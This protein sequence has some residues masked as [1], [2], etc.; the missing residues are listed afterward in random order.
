[1]EAKNKMSFYDAEERKEFT[2]FNK[3]VYLK[4]TPGKHVIRIL[5]AEARKYYS[6]WISGTSIE[7]LGDDCPQCQL[8]DSILVEVNNKYA[9][10]KNVTGFSYRQARGVVNVLDRTPVK[11]CVKCQDEMKAINNVWPAACR[12]CGTLTNE[13]EIT[14]SGKVKLLSKADIVFAQ[15]GSFDGSVLDED[16]NALGLMDFDLNLITVGNNTVADPT[17]TIDKVSVPDDALFDLEKASIRLDKDEM[18]QRI[19]GVSLKDIFSARNVET[20]VAVESSGSTAAI[21]AR[22][23]E[24]FGVDNPDDD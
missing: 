5:Q 20:S 1:M 6:H 19:R 11:I 17:S 23:D 8:N 24:I 15:I 10:A 18:L 16:G 2:P 14:T 21:E 4:T 12:L 13:V 22:V 9:D 7:C 3:P